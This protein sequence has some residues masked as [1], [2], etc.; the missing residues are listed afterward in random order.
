MTSWPRFSFWAER[1]SWPVPFAA[2]LA[3]TSLTP[4]RG[5][6]CFFGAAFF[7][8]EAGFF[9]ADFFTDGG[10]ATLFFA[11]RGRV[12]AFTERQSSSSAA[13]SFFE[14]PV[15]LF[16]LAY[17]DPKLPRAMGA[18]LHLLFDVGSPRG[19]GHEHGGRRKVWCFLS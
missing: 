18:K 17:I 5:G 10:F 12:P 11:P 3:G 1:R 16:A 13:P 8:A 15:I 2:S 9:F 14:E 6:V 19:A 4:V 7:F